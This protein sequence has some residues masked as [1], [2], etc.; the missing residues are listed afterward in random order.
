M[1]LITGATGNGGRPLV[2]LLISQRAQVRAL[3]RDP[4]SAGL[5]AG[6]D[7]VGDDPSRP[8]AIA[9]AL[10]G[11]DAVFVNPRAVGGAGAELLL[12]ARHAGVRKVVVLSAINVDDDFS[13]QPSRFR[14]DRNKEA[15]D[16]AI[17]SGLDWISLRP[18]TFATN[19]IGL[20]GAQIRAGD[21]VRG[22]Y[23][24]ATEAS[25]DPRDVAAV[26]CAALLTDT[27]VGRRISLTGPTSL[28][29]RETVARIGGAVGKTIRYQEVSPQATQQAMSTLGFPAEFVAANLARL[30]ASVGRP[31]PVSEEF[32]QILGRPP[33]SFDRWAA[34]HAQAFRQ[35]GATA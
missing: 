26:A 6:V 20:W 2:D 1:I 14:G 29:Q 27:L 28:T 22:P 7:L 33:I 15:E 31:A 24:D 34:D 32:E 25:I 10:Q 9:A 4:S 21:C 17:A 5:P 12:L 19:A 23:A 18:T 30:A 35:Q 13:R 3:S 11:V 16:A 8:A